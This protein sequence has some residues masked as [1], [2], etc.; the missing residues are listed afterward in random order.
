[1]LIIHID[2]VDT[3]IAREIKAFLLNKNFEVADNDAGFNYHVILAKSCVSVAPS[4]TD[5]DSDA[6]VSTTQSFTSL[7]PPDEID[8]VA[9][10]VS[11]LGISGS[12]ADYTSVAQ[13]DTPSSQSADAACEPY[14]NVSGE[15]CLLD[16]SYLRKVQF[17]CNTESPYSVLCARNITKLSDVI[18]FEFNGTTFKY[19]L[20]KYYSAKD[21]NCVNSPPAGFDDDT[22]LVRCMLS[23]DDAVKSIFLRVIESEICC[24][25]FGSDLIDAVQQS[26]AEKLQNDCLS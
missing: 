23:D 25:V 15:V 13:S 6:D 24:V 18:S 3:E 7:L 12:P 26:Q 9:P 20:A 11:T 17:T 8:A 5:A 21:V 1:M 4:D 10:D 22:I 19:P 16:I 2:T 14:T